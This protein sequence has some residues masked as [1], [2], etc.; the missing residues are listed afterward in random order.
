MLGVTGLALELHRTGFKSWLS[1]FYLCDFWYMTLLHIAKPL[2][3]HHLKGM[4]I[5]PNSKEN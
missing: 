1:T 2:F 5:E 3:H 4:I